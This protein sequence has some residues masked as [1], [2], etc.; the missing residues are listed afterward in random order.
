MSGKNLA[1][2]PFTLRQ[3]DVFERLSE[4]GSFRETSEALGISQAA[5]SNQIKA[6]EEQLGQRLL[7]RAKGRQPELTSEG[8]DF[9]ADLNLFREAAMRLASHR[10]R[11]RPLDEATKPK[12]FTVFASHYIFNKLIRPRLAQFLEMNGNLELNIRADFFDMNPSDRLSAADHDFLLLHEPDSRDL[13]PNT[14]RVARARTGVFGHRKFRQSLSAPITPEQVNELPFVLPPKGSHFEKL[15]LR[16]FAE[17]GIR[18]R[19]IVARAQYFDVICSLLEK[20]NAVGGTLEPFLSIE[21]RESVALLYP[22]HPVRIA[23]YRNPD[24]TGPEAN[25]VEEF[26]VSAVLA[27]PVYFDR[28]PA[29]APNQ[30]V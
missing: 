13:A 4:L 8:I 24:C 22:V 11:A 12:A 23:L 30:L 18:P 21:Q 15:V 10:R 26:L 16:E 17:F 3:L 27:D 9:L 14:R 29:A 7:N 20:G 5:V 28:E 19:N 6:L 2:L 25:A 1:G